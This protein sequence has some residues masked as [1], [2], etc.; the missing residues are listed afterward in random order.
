MTGHYD[1]T[2]PCAYLVF[3]LT[4][5][6]WV[7]FT[8]QLPKKY[9]TLYLIMIK[10]RASITI[11]PWMAGKGDRRG[12][13]CEDE[14]EQKKDGD[15][16]DTSSS[17]EEEAEGGRKEVPQIQVVVR[18]RRRRSARRWRKACSRGTPLRRPRIHTYARTA[19]AAD[20]NNSLL[21]FICSGEMWGQSN[22]NTNRLSTCLS[23]F[24]F[25]SCDQGCFFFSSY[26]NQAAKSSWHDYCEHYIDLI[27]PLWWMWWPALCLPAAPPFPSYGAL[28]LLTSP[29]L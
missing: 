3:F 22:P 12:T 10:T 21:I 7:K 15:G 8:K 28:T 26:E 6:W 17:H 9:A 16:K 2:L 14:A 23:P 1:T 19:Q 13:R 4:Y 11:K 24:P 27:F 20:I 29:L 18:K 25:F 5:F